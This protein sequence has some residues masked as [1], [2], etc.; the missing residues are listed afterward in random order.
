MFGSVV[1]EVAIGLAFVYFVFSIFAS[2]IKEWI[3]KILALRA[4][5]LENGIV[6]MLNPNARPDQ[7]DPFIREVIDHP[8]LKEY[9]PTRAW[10]KWPLLSRLPLVKK[11]ASPTFVPARQFS[12]ALCETLLKDKSCPGAADWVTNMRERIETV[13][14]PIIRQKL[15]T[16][17]DSA[18]LRVG[19]AEQKT[20]EVLKEIE[21]WYDNNM[22]QV[23]AW[24]K[25]KAKQIIFVIS[26][27]LCFVCN[28]D[29]IAITTYLLHDGAMRQAVVE[30]A[31]QTVQRTNEVGSQPGAAALIPLEQN[32]ENMNLPMGWR[33]SEAGATGATRSWRKPHNTE[34]F[35]FKL[36]GLLISTFAVSLG[37]PFWFDLLNRLVNLRATGRGKTN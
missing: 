35:L 31:Q 7:L 29:S 10:H 19:G 32:L 11:L 1:L 9:A 8:L 27:A 21:S 37:A 22:A 33:K 3:A 18:C 15:V 6:Y 14:N 28:I 5:T 23:S 30:M 16:L 17:F 34:A 36:F 20:A 25:R 2:G 13:G 12:A 4:Q 26:F 24:Y